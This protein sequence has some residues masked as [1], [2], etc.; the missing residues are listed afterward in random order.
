MVPPLGVLALRFSPGCLFPQRGYLLEHCDKLS[1]KGQEN[2]AKPNSDYRQV[3][4]FY[5]PSLPRCLT[6]CMRDW[7]H[8]P[9]MKGG[10]G[11][12]LSA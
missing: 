9:R 5:N 7:S 10:G 8:G 11:N 1:M 12:N 3:E 6:N 2:S 4:S